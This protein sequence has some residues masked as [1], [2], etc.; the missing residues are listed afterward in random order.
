MK[1]PV[2]HD[3]D[4]RAR[5][6]SE[7]RY[8]ALYERERTV[9]RQ[10]ERLVNATRALGST[11]DLKQVLATILHELQNVVPYD[12]ASVQ[13]L[14]GNFLE[15]IGAV[16]FANPGEILGTSFDVSLPGNPN[17]DVLQQ[18]SAIVVD[19][20]PARYPSFAA[21]VHQ[22]TPIRSWIGVP[23]LFGDRLI[24]MLALDKKEPTFYTREHAE[25]A[26]S[27]AP[28]AAIAI[29][30]ARLYATAQ[31][32]LEERKR[33]EGQLLQAQKMEAVGRLAGG[34][35]HDFNN[36]LGVIMG[37]GNILLRQ[38][39][40]GPIRHKLEE[41]VRAGER[42]AALTHQLLAFSRRQVLQPRI[43]DLAG[44]VEGVDSMLRRLVGED[45]DIR[46]S[47]EPGLWKVMADPGQV[48]Q[49]IVN[50]AINARDAMPQGG[51]L[52]IEAGN[53]RLPR[54]PDL[55]PAFEPG[56]Y[57]ALMV[58]DTGVGM[59]EDTRNHIFEPFFTTKEQGTGL[60]LATVYGIVRQSGGHISV[61]SE[62]GVGTTFRIYLPR[63]LQ[64]QPAAPSGPPVADELH[65]R[66]VILV[67]EDMDPLR[68]MIQEVLEDYG[69]R[70]LTAS[71]GA[72]AVQ[73]AQAHDGAIDL[74]LTDVVMPVM[75]GR[76]VADI[77][78]ASRP[79][80]RVLYMSGF[81]DDAIV[82]HG[83]IDH[84]VAFLEKPFDPDTLLRKVRETLQE[85]RTA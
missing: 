38:V 50:L 3:E 42:A 14:R 62:P 16:G 61:D 75:S 65:G 30:N 48:E 37:Y 63:A 28:Q 40:E 47:T 24:G 44:A 34:V 69:Y 52:T 64:G 1:A 51:M 85:A 17:R 72:E 8:K 7:E 23:L 56:D 39:E 78:T 5:R 33:I 20:A 10:A 83:V 26:E 18:R 45:V 57:V 74:L 82:R 59:T 60:G 29:E 25:I 55:G 2:P 58:R 32:E 71:G 13:V 11:L 19:D 73:R 43:L 76:Q 41:I 35:A 66:E 80:L 6:E 54:R 22:R 84:Q 4:E 31:Q 79:G 49:V 9:R 12:S 53:V 27:F 70:V 46:T 21:G 81:T 68:E 15:I 67:V 77:L 36:I